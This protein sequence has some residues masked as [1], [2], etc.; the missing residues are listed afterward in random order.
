MEEPSPRSSRLALAGALAAAIA[1]GGAGFLLGRAAQ[2]RPP[3]PVAPPVAPPPT[4]EPEPV[5]SGLLDRAD[6]LAL[7][8]EAAD[9]AA[10]GRDPGPEVAR[11]DGRRFELRLPFGCAG[12]AAGDSAAPM[13]WRYDSKAEALRISV[14][15]VAWTA[16]DWWPADSANGVEAIEGFWVDRPWTSSEACPEAGD[17]PAEA[18]AAEASEPAA[19]TERTLALG[20][21]FFAESGRGGRRNGKPYQAV[22]RVAGDQLDSSAGFRLR[23][24]GRIARAGDV[25]PVRCRRPTGPARRPTCLV[26]VVMDEVTVEN[27][28]NGETL[29]TWSVGTGKAPE[30]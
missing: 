15:P 25:G 26:S 24:A 17:P 2:E 20:Q 19:P 11:A 14:D 13:R 21:L 12:P 27:A 7:A 29:A 1:V 3:A 10:A 5:L 22:V 30:S 16:N 4:P 9:A 8:A 6:L 23:I 18:G 28:A